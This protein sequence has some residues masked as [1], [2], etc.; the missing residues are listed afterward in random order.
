MSAAEI[1]FA[2]AGVLFAITVSVTVSLA[3]AVTANQDLARRLDRTVNQLDT[4]RIHLGDPA[5]L[6]AA[7]P[8]VP[9]DDEDELR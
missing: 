6:H 1:A 8:E 5:R 4:Y 3:R 9:R 2:G 7:H